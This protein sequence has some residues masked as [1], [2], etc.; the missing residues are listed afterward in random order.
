MV[1]GRTRNYPIFQ[2]LPSLL[3]LLFVGGSAAFYWDRLPEKMASH[4]DWSG[5]PNGWTTPTATVVLLVAV[6][7]LNWGIDA[8]ARYQCLTLERE[9]KRFNWFQFLMAPFVLLISFVWVSLLDFNV[10][11][12]PFGF[13]WQLF[14]AVTFSVWAFL[15]ATENLR[16]IADSDAGPTLPESELTEPLPEKFCLVDQEAPLWWTVLSLSSGLFL[17]LTGGALVLAKT[18]IL[19]V[20][21]LL[22]LVGFILLSFAGGF[23]F[24]VHPKAVEISLAIGPAFKTIPMDKVLR[25]QVREFSPLQEFGGWGIRMGLN[26]TTGY[27]VSGTSGVFIETEGRNYLLA[28]SRAATLV[29]AIEAVRAR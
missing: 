15:A 8:M 4:F 26:K 29:D 14:L 18:G 20:G 9:I 7:M 13:R 19:A 1:L 2:E 10:F 23:R 5:Q 21:V 25:A 12:S 27:I 17:C 16:G 22:V 28:T 11:G 3:G 6:L 24:V